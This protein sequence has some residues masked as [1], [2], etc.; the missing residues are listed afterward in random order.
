MAAAIYICVPSLTPPY[1]TFQFLGFLAPS[2][3]SGGCLGRCLQ[4]HSW[5]TCKRDLN[6]GSGVGGLTCPRI[7]TT[8]TLPCLSGCSGARIRA[9]VRITAAWTEPLQAPRARWS[10]AVEE[11]PLAGGDGEGACERTEGVEFCGVR[12][13]AWRGGT[14][15][16][17][18]ASQCS[19]ECGNV[20]YPTSYA[21]N[22][23]RALISPTGRDHLQRC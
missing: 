17:H 18:T 16:A 21:R 12:K 1:H 14:Q 19:L 5:S 3:R 10:D 4:P 13:G 6:G 11:E 22:R 23:G 7:D 9:L 15:R 8:P 20:L 2:L